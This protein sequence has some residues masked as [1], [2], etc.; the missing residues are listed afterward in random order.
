MISNFFR[1]LMVL[2]TMGTSL[3]FLPESLVKHPKNLMD[4]NVLFRQNPGILKKSLKRMS[5]DDISNEYEMEDACENE[6][7]LMN[8]RSVHGVIS[9]SLGYLSASMIA[10]SLESNA[11]VGTLPEFSD[12]NAIVQ[13]ITINVAESKQF[14]DMVDFLRDGLN[15]QVLRQENKGSISS[16]WLGFGPEQANIPS[17][18]V[19]PVSSFA[20]YGGHA[21]IE[22]R[23]DAKSTTSFYDGTSMGGNNIAYLQVGVPS[24][25]ISQMVAHGGNVIDAYGLVNIISPAGLPIRAIVG[26]SPDPIMFLAI[27]SSDVKQSKAFYEAIGMMEQEYPYAR[28]NK[29]MGQFEPPMPK[30]SIYLSH[31]A[32]SMGVLILPTEKKKQKVSANPAFQCMRIVYNPSDPLDEANTK[33]IETI[34]PS[35]VNISF[36]PYSRFEKEEAAGAAA[37]QASESD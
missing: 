21:S 34:D 11:A 20:K 9:A 37:K 7:G 13:G 2:G 14:F 27:Y 4:A 18:F 10:P 12:T 30:N 6:S 35:S 1:F 15:F 32:N 19:L 26:I 31:S 29:G 25:R 3:A 5:Y 24:Y 36:I 16:V 33:S 23:F 8:R 17:D 28:P 22:I